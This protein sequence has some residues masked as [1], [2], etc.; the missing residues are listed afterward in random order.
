MYY[1]DP[2][3]YFT[4]EKLE[5]GNIIIMHDT[6]HGNLRKTR[7]VI[8]NFNRFYVHNKNIELVAPEEKTYFS[9]RF[10]R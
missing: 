10:G 6:V 8:D 7:G 2:L 9:A 3:V 4:T 5:N 1:S